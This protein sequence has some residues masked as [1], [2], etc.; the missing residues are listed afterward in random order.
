MTMEIYTMMGN[1]KMTKNTARVSSIALKNI[2]KDNGKWVK[3][4][5]MDITSTKQPKNHTKELS[6]T[7][8]KTERER[9]FTVMEVFLREF[10][11]MTYLM[12]LDIFNLPTKIGIRATSSKERKREKGLTISVKAQYSKEFGKITSKLKVS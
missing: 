11:I 6:H 2:T 7:I 1:G 9:A 10:Y 12:G 3:N 5:E 8:E 4:K